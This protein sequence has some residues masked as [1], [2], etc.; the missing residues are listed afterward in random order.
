MNKFDIQ[1]ILNGEKIDG[2]VL[3]NK[4]DLIIDT[5]K[6]SYVIKYI[7]IEDICYSDNSIVIITESKEYVI[8]T[9]DVEIIRDVLNEKVNLKKEVIID[10]EET[11]LH[12]NKSSGIKIVL[13]FISV[14][15]L[16]GVGLFTFHDKIVDYF[17][18]A[19]SKTYT[20]IP[21]NIQG[22]YFFQKSTTRV[23]YDYYLK[24]YDT[25]IDDSVCNRSFNSIQDIYSS[26][27]DFHYSAKNINCTNDNNCSFDIYKLNEKNQEE[28]TATCTTSIG[29][30]MCVYL[31]G[32]TYTYSKIES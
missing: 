19:N 20:T 6:T 10:G 21:K 2:L 3:F 17:N 13:S 11:T 8:D 12:N 16:V 31:S 9:C 14:V 28:K 22:K 25:K 18:N 15:I 30:I 26:C 29:T 7:N 23:I 32:V 5:P 1:F 27:M 4:E 24:I